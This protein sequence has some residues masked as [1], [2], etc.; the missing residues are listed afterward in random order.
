M[1]IKIHHLLDHKHH[2]PTV[3]AWQQAEFGYLSPNATVEERAER[4]RA[5]SDKARLPILKR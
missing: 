3:A 5:A 4:L 1:S 2:I